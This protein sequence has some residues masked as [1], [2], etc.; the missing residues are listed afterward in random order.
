MWRLLA[1][2]GD[3]EPVVKPL[4]LAFG[5][6]DSLVDQKSRGQIQ[7]VLGKKTDVPHE[8]RIYDDQIHGFALRSDWSHEN[9][10]RAMDEA[11]TQGLEWFKKYLA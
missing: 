7:D 8:I 4:S 2:P 11:T 5:E 10:K 9:D 6:K 1:I 3:L